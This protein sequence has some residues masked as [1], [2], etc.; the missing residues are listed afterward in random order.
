MAEIKLDAALLRRAAKRNSY[1]IPEDGLLFFGVRGALPIDITGSPFAKSH[2]LRM[3][4]FNHVQMRCTL[5]QMRVAKDDLAVF[6]GSTVPSIENVRSAKAAG[7]VGANMLMLGC[8]QY[9]QG[10]HK[11]GKP[12]G[13][14]AF[15]Q[16]V[17]FPVWRS[18]DDLD[19]DLNDRADLDGDIVADNLHCAFHDNID[20]PGFSSAGCQVIAGRPTMAA[21]GN[22]PETGPWKVFV[23]NAYKLMP[24]QP[25]YNYLLFSAAELALVALKKDKDLSCTLRFGSEG[26]LVTKLQQALIAKGLP[27][28]TADGFFGR[29]TIDAVMRFQGQEFGRGTA[30][31]IVGP[32]T[33]A[34]MGFALPKLG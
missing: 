15:R 32:N 7:G 18:A 8:Y 16:S 19:F 11:A 22:R 1:P 14:R 29:D 34:A 5:G 9:H 3:S 20:T 12:S 25:R 33:A 4:D 28:R 30:D 17:F 6:P 2:A 31:G 23:E 21:N 24:K 13:H 10:I 26:A 27:L